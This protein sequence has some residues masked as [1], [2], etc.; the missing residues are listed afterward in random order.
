MTRHRLALAFLVLLALSLFLPALVK[1]EVFTLRDHFDYFQPLRWFTATELQAG[2]VPLWNPYSAS[3]EPWMA[4]PQT[5]LF[6][7]PAW[8][9]LVLPFTTAYTLFLFLHVAL[10]GCSAYLLFARTASREAAF[11]GAVALMFSGPVLSLMDVSNNL[12]TFAWIPLALWCAAEGAWRRGGI[13]LALA[14]LG[15]EP[16]FAAVA[17]VLFVVASGGLRV[18]WKAGMVAFG[19]SAIQLFPF[20]EMV[21]RS[22]RA[23]GLDASLVLT[24]S[25]SLRDWLHVALPMT[26]GRTQQFI[27][28]VYASVIVCIL[29]LL[30]IRR[31]TLPWLALFVAAFLISLGPGFLARLPLTIFRYPARLVPLAALAIAALA[32]AG[33]ERFRTKRRWVDVAVVA[34]VL[35]DLV[36]RVWPLLESAP[37]RTDVVPY[38]GAVA[39]ETKFLRIDPIDASKRAAWISGY[40]NLYDR[41]FDSFTAA[42]VVF[43]DYVRMHRALLA[44][45]TGEELARK[46]IAWLVTTRD[47]RIPPAARAAN[48]AVYHNRDTFPMAYLIVR[49]PL[50]VLPLRVRLDSSHAFVTVDA[51]REG[52]VVVLQ[53]H[54]P[55][56][57]VYLDGLESRSIVVDR[58]FRGVQVTQGHHRIVWKYRPRSLFSGA[59]VTSITLLAMT[60]FS[61]VKRAR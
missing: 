37:F 22:D 39:A 19:L 36:P 7:P 26:S 56:W 2:R 24:H 3:G 13:V 23:A 54:D 12:T 48:V 34:L 52:V 16:F 42:P 15:G 53:Q 25:M 35:I 51:P 55:G 5:G 17:A 32:V 49:E 60:L 31:R 9:F 27:P 6:Y 29:A 46:A 41:R 21:R 47:L 61:F 20:L 11:V 50:S 59:A 57:R 58:L 1:N 28:V 4:N 10:L 45:P 30:G 44:K 8:L 33:W 14:F 18:A 38:P 43:D 40:L